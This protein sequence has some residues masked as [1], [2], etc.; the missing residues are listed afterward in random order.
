MN[1][2]STAKKI[3]IWAGTGILLCLAC[4][5]YAGLFQET[6]ASAVFGKL[7]DSCL[8]VGVIF[9]GVG[10]LSY[11]AGEGF[12]DI[13]GYGIKTVWKLFRTGK[14]AGEFADYKAEKAKERRPWRKEMFFTGLGFLLLSAVFWLLYRKF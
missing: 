4:A 1:E 2:L 3:L 14:P 5:G 8:I 9:G 11:M 7:S 12:Y 13:F 10:G 6:S